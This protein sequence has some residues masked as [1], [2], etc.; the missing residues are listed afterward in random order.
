MFEELA[1]YKK[2]SRL[3]PVAWQAGITDRDALFRLHPKDFEKLAE[4]AGVRPPSV[5]TLIIVAELI[6]AHA[7]FD[8]FAKLEASYEADRVRSA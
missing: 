8:P 7:S 3:A 2:A 5:L 6:E 4:A 1:R